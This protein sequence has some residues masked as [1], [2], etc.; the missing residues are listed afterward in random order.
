ML[1]ER[2]KLSFNQQRKDIGR[3]PEYA[4]PV[5][6]HAYAIFGD[7]NSV[8]DWITS[9]NMALGN[10]PLELLCTSPESAKEVDNILYRIES[11]AYS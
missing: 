5:L 9:R 1:E 11:G 8:L 2:L 10:V 4:V 3:L 6:E 7:Y